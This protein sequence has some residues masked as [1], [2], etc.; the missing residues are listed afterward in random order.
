LTPTGPAAAQRP[1]LHAGIDA[2]A[3][4]SATH[5]YT[6]LEAV[7]QS[8]MSGYVDG[9]R[10]RVIVITDGPN[11]GGL[12]YPQIKSRLQELAAGKG[13]LPVSFI[14]VGPDP[15]RKELTDLAKSTGGTASVLT[16]AK[17]V[18]AALGQLLSVDS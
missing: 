16:N 8:A 2:L 18:D 7:Y 4:A 14:A 12:S 17:G 5:L 9:K 3:P 6:S 11:D 1:A 10:N 13:K 15:D